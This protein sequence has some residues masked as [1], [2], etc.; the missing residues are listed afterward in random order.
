MKF[1]EIVPRVARAVL[2]FN[3]QTA[4]FFAFY[5]QPFE[6]AARSNSIEPVAALVHSDADIERVFRCAINCVIVG[7]GLFHMKS[8]GCVVFMRQ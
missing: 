6:T 1:K 7:A 4:P 8:S 3:P 2:L 5:Q